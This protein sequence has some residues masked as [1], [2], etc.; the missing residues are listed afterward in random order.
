[1]IIILRKISV[2]MKI[3]SLV[4]IALVTTLLFAATYLANR[5]ATKTA[6]DVRE[7]IDVSQKKLN[8]I[9]L[10]LAV[11]HGIEQRFLIE[12]SA[13]AAGAFDKTQNRLAAALSELQSSDIAG[14]GGFGDAMSAA[15]KAYAG[16]VAAAIAIQKDIGF[17]DGFKVEV[18]EDGQVKHP[19]SL[20]SKLSDRLI[21]AR[22]RL[23]EEMDFSEDA[24]LVRFAAEVAAI[25]EL[26]AKLVLYN[27]TDYSSLIDAKLESIKSLLGSEELDG[28]FVEEF[29]GHLDQYKVLVSQ[30][31]QAYDALN[32]RFGE[33]TASH[34]ALTAMLAPVDARL[35]A[36]LT[37]AVAGFS[38]QQSWSDTA[39]A[40][41]IVGSLIILLGC[42]F[43]IGRDL[44]VSL[45]R[46]TENM[47][48]LAGG[49]TDISVKG[50]DRADEI[51]KMSKAV[52]VF[53]DNAVER[54]RLQVE[55][56]RRD[57]NRENRQQRTESLI[58]GFRTQ[59]QQLLDALV[60]NSNQMQ[61]TSRIL[62]DVAEETSGRANS[63]ADAS[64]EASGNVDTVATAAEELSSSVS[65]ISHQVN[66]TTAIAR[67]ANDDAHASNEKVE[68][69]AQAIQRISDVVVLIKDIAEQ[70]NLLALNAT[71]EAAR[72]GEMGRGFAVVASEVKALATQTAK[73]TEEIATQIG[74][75][76]DETGDAVG[77]IQSIAATIDQ[78]NSYTASIA[79]AVEKQGA[80]T[81][82][83]SSNVVLAASGTQQVA[84]NIAGVTRAVAETLQ[85]AEQVEQASTDVATQADEIR[86]TID[87]F[88]REVT[89]A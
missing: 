81:A 62:S 77:T 23:N 64:R 39:I 1:M 3:V 5:Q 19:D 85:S 26:Q 65:E 6:F 46:L 58:A 83:I 33:V 61:E 42:G 35:G 76:Q 79:S 7:S 18:Q 50:L 36:A 74:A 45:R 13:A 54:A 48:R 27:S 68:S 41:T 12:R 14:A 75:I 40:A 25:S 59:I 72:A 52:Q 10:Q 37:D 63:V 82:E 70:T 32:A 16:A 28:S 4:G 87:D 24:I 86:R 20:T 66:E 47:N 21:F 51:G 17:T 34:E 71:I 11:L 22:K 8:D 69:L 43:V 9:S 57:V 60:D 15:F 80:A 55:A 30:W 31:S 49:D 78:V 67:K 2:R 84:D 88:L 29:G 73:A 89:A 44:V 53:R 38:A 56:E